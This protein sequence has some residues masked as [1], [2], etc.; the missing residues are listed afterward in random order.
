MTKQQIIKDVKTLLEAHN[1]IDGP[2]YL[3]SLQGPTVILTVL[4][5]SKMTPEIKD[6]IK[7]TGAL[8]L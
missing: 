6:L 3:I 8:I 7:D 1:I 5:T 4:G 2:D